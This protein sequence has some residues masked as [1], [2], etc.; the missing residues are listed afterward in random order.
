MLLPSSAPGSSLCGE[1]DRSA[2]QSRIVANDNFAG[3]LFHIVAISALVLESFAKIAGEQKIRVFWRNTAGQQYPLAVEKRPDGQPVPYVLVRGRL[4]AR[5]SRNVFYHLVEL[6]VA[7]VCEGSEVL[8]VYSAGCRF[9]L[10]E[11]GV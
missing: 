2:H 4:R 9:V 3:D 1:A 8:A 11:T 6:A 10:G 5:L 7:E